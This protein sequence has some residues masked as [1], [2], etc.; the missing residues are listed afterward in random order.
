MNLKLMI[1]IAIF[2]IL[3]GPVSLWAQEKN[4]EALPSSE[5]IEFL[6]E[7]GDDDVGWVDPL[8]LPDMEAPEQK[9]SQT[10]EE[11]DSES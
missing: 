7:F 8:E 9:T 3:L 1:S 5:L 2:S 10:K 11:G 6:G 4:E